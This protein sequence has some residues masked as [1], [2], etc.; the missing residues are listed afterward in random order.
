MVEYGKLLDDVA[1]QV[2]RLDIPVI[3]FDTEQA[4]LAVEADPQC[5][6]VTRG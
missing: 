4:R 6:A 2:Q 5:R 1:Y 3:G